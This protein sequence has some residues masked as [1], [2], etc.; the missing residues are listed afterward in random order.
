MVRSVNIRETRMCN[1]YYFDPNHPIFV[2]DTIQKSWQLVDWQQVMQGG[3]MESK[4]Q[5][6][7]QV[8]R[9]VGYLE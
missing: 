9:Y 2:Q 4:I 5:C 3:V 8:K 1:D 7:D 6:S